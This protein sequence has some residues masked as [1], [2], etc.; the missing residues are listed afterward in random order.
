[1]EHYINKGPLIQI[2]DLNL[3]LDGKQILRN[4]NAEVDDISR[5]DHPE[6][7]QGQIVAFGGPSGIGKSQLSLCLAGLQKPNSGEILI[8]P[9]AKPVKAGDVG[10]VTQDSAI[11]M[12]RSVLSNLTIAGR[13]AGL[14]KKD[15]NE[16]AMFYLKQ[17]GLEKDKNKYPKSL[18]GGQRQRLAISQQFISS[19]HYIIMDEPFASLDILNKQIVCNQLIELSQLDELNTFVVISHDIPS[20]LAISDVAWFMGRDRDEKGNIIPGAYIKHT[21]DL[22]DTGYDLCWKDDPTHPIQRDPRFMELVA[23]V[24]FDIFP[25][26]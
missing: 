7:K 2:K 9:T 6:I 21:F 4:L 17:F 23:H 25:N 1:M 3:V 19:S 12:H 24:Q 10:F 13:L 18:S 15:A 22:K 20:M 5:P 8:G 16:K 14:S 26:L 11:F